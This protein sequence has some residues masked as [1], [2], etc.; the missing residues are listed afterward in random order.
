MQKHSC[1]SIESIVRI[2]SIFTVNEANQVKWPDYTSCQPIIFFLLHSI[3]CFALASQLCR[4]LNVVMIMRA[5]LLAR[6]RDYSQCQF[7]SMVCRFGYSVSTVLR[8]RSKQN[9]NE[10]NLI[11]ILYVQ[12]NWEKGKAARDGYGNTNKMPNEMYKC[13]YGRRQ[14]T[15]LIIHANVRINFFYSALCVFGRMELMSRFN[16]TFVRLTI[17]PISSCCLCFFF[18]CRLCTLEV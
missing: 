9:G 10:E 5:L 17:P 8:R 11:C 13:K 15:F 18:R 6:S 3:H 16:F 2:T 14:F 7:H 1:R 4:L 12:I